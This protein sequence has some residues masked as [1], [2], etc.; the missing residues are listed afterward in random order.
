MALPRGYVLPRLERFPVARGLDVRSFRRRECFFD[1]RIELRVD[2][3]NG[4]PTVCRGRAITRPES[5]RCLFP[6]YDPRSRAFCE[7]FLFYLVFNVLYEEE[8]SLEE[9]PDLPD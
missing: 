1:A 2:A 7:Q 4:T 5:S 8:I 6:T 9:W 3:A